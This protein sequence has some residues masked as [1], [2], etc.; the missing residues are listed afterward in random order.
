MFGRVI[1]YTFR[2]EI[3]SF[4]LLFFEGINRYQINGPIHH[5]HFLLIGR[6]FPLWVPTPSF[7]DT[8]SSFASML[9][10]SLHKLSLSLCTLIG[11]IGNVSL[12]KRRRN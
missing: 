6:R 9:D 7:L 2:L 4:I 10:F 1:C 5:A 11:F 3:S 8:K 12:W